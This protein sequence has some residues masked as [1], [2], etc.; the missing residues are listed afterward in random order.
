[1]GEYKGCLLTF[2]TFL[3]IFCSLL[4]IFSSIQFS[5]KEGYG[6]DGILSLLNEN[7]TMLE[8]NKKE[9]DKYISDLEYKKKIS[10]INSI[11]I[12][13]YNLSVL[14]Y[15]IIRLK[16]IVSKCLIDIFIMI[17]IFLGNIAELV[18]TINVWNFYFETNG[19][20]ENEG[21]DLKE[22]YQCIKNHIDRTSFE[23]AESD[24]ESLLDLYL[25]LYFI[26]IFKLLFVFFHFLFI[27]LNIGCK[28]KPECIADQFRFICEGLK[29]CF[30]CFKDCFSDCCGNIC[31]C[32]SDCC[33]G[34]CE[35]CSQ[36]CGSFHNCLSNCCGSL[37]NCISDCC[38]SM[39]KGISDCC[40][41]C[42]D[43]C[44]HCCGSL[45]NCI[46][47]C[48]ESICKGISDCCSSCCGKCGQCCAKCCGNDYDSLKKENGNL[49]NK[50]KELEKENDNLKKKI[51]KN[52]N[53][54]TERKNLGDEIAIINDDDIKIRNLREEKIST[55]TIEN[56]RN[57]IALNENKLTELKRDNNI[58]RE[59]LNNLQNGVPKTIEN[60][61]MKV[62]E[63]YLRKEKSKE[64]CNYNYFLS[65]FLLKEINEKY[66][67]YLDSENFK[68]IA[69]YYIKSK[70]IEHLTDSKSFK[71]FSD[72]VIQNDG[73]TLDRANINQEK[74]FVENKLVSKIIE[75]LNKNKDLQMNDLNTI[76]QLLKNEKTNNYYNNPVVIIKGNNKGE[77][78]ERGHN[79]INQNYKNTV[80]QNIIND[81]KEFFEDDFFK[82]KGLE[83]EGMK[84]FIDYNNIMV[85]NFVSSDGIINE[86][87]ACLKT[88]LFAE[89]EEKLYKIY[90]NYKE[91]NNI[92]LNGGNQVLRFKTI[93]ENNI[94]DRDKIVMQISE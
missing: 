9:C 69:L 73:I 30:H 88:D 63:F 17:I 42:C 5:N 87:I 51:M 18:F 54:I 12:F 28:G 34:C 80:I 64:F 33:S 4:I 66:G 1:M 20:S 15:L 67:L 25:A 36:C 55:N 6:Y 75:I 50:I 23:E 85:I 77:T 56:L 13:L 70:L 78:I 21:Y 92:F 48:C 35:K 3:I 71:I 58:L 79:L 89:V 24:S 8:E 61:Q 91:T 46:P 81:L 29:K 83:A 32:L 14:I 82:F 59:E 37:C 84:K 76:K 49:R 57:Q 22:A 43:K 93:E 68:K 39:C 27:M 65:N 72:P 44:G 31:E 53:I 86:G 60:M 90:E 94:K 45:C 62:I 16:D 47:D 52:N 26:V 19:K 74:P 40:S 11:Y 7:K 10:K 41:F 2:S 38:S